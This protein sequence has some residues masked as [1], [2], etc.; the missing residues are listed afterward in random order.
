MTTF[1]IIR[2]G[3]SEANVKKIVQGNGVGNTSLTEKGK[4][5]AKALGDLVKNV[6]FD[7]VY[8]SDLL[9]AIQ[10]AK[11][12]A[13]EYNLEVY[14][15][16]RLRERSQGKFEGMP[17]KEFLDLYTSENWDPLTDEQKFA[18]KLDPTQENF[19]ESNTRF[20]QAITEYARKYPGKTI[21]VVTHGGIIRGLL[22]SH[23]Y[24]DFDKVGGIINCGYVK[25]ESDGKEIQIKEVYGL[26]TWEEKRTT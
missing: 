19:I 20:T 26:K 17:V 1:Y 6:H 22:I 15:D 3:E 12:I 18:H 8:S 25:A 23:K 21:L 24:G 10:T 4:E 11:I 13:I 16:K 14:P 2:H 5:Q 7:Y 9:R